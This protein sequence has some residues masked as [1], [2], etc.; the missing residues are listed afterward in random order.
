MIIFRREPLR[1]AIHR[2]RSAAVGMAHFVLR[3]AA[4]LY[5]HALKR[6]SSAG[7]SIIGA[8]HGF[9]PRA[10]SSGGAFQLVVLLWAATFFA[11][12]PAEAALSMPDNSLRNQVQLQGYVTSIVNTTDFVLD[13]SQLIRT[14]ERTTFYGITTVEELGIGDHVSVEGLFEG[15]TAVRATLVAVFNGDPQWVTIEDVVSEIVDSTTFILDDTTTV[16]IYAGTELDG[17]STVWDLNAEDLV[18][19]EGWLYD[20]VLL[21]EYVL[22][23]DEPGDPISVE[24][25]VTAVVSSTEFMLDNSVLVLTNPSTQ[26]IGFQSIPDLAPG[27]LVTVEGTTSLNGVIAESVELLSSPGDPVQMTGIVDE[28]L[29]QMRFRLIDGSIVVTDTRTDF[30]GIG[31]VLDLRPGDLVRTWGWWSENEFL[32]SWVEFIESMPELQEVTG[33]LAYLDPPNAFVLDDQT[34]VEVTDE[35]EWIALDGYDQLV[36][37]DELR[38]LGYSD[39][40]EW[41]WTIAAVEVER[42][43][44][45]GPTW[46]TREGWVEEVTG[47]L[48]VRLTDGVV[49]EVRPDAVLSELDSVE[50]LGP[51]DQLWIAAFTTANPQVLDVVRLEL[52]ER[53]GN[54]IIFVSVVESVNLSFDRFSTAN[55]YE[56]VIDDNT[57]FVNVNGLTEIVVGD[58][59]AVDG[60][61]GTDPLHPEQVDAIVVERRE[62]EDNGGDDGGSGGGLRTTVE[63]IVTELR[64]DGVFEID[65]ERLVETTEETEWRN[66]LDALEDLVVGMPVRTEIILE[67]DDPMEAVWVEGFAWV[68]PGIVDIEGFVLEIDLETSRF[69]LE[70]GEWL[71]WDDLTQID[72][73][74]DTFAEIEPGMHVIVVAVD[75][76]DNVFFALEI[77]VELEV[78]DVGA[79]GFPDEPIR[80]TLVVLKDGVAASEVATRYG[81]VVTG[82]LPG[83]MVHLF[84]WEETVN[85]T[86]LQTVLDDEDVVVLEPNRLFSDPESDPESIRRRA[87]AIDRA[88]TSDTFN[89]QDALFKAALDTAHTRSL[90]QGTLVAVIDTGVD[91]FHPLLRHRIAPGGYDFVDEDSLPWETADGIDQDGDEEIDEG[92]GHGTFVAGLVLLAAPATSILP[93]RVLD[94]DGRGSTFDISRA[95]LLAIDLGA[96]VINMSFAYPDRSRVLDRILMEASSRGVVLV[97]GAGNTGLATLPFPAADNRVLAVAAIDGDGRLTDFSNRGFEIALG[98]PGVDLYSASPGTLF[99]T[100]SGTSMAAPLV[101]GT[102]ALLRSVNPYLTPDQIS[103]ALLQGA[104]AAHPDDGLQLVLQAGAAI[105][106]VPNGP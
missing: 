6:G 98:A 16:T 26:L 13:D 104:A 32:A 103:A 89:N 76:G 101:S 25:Y 36:A 40:N 53:P 64:A 87:I 105:D 41:T 8:T 92:A 17:F 23:V 50:D 24:G 15:D 43:G 84:R 93:F 97:S 86:I 60:I 88:A 39:G 48:T 85:E 54:H 34:R 66:A 20:E 63:G 57:V 37:G 4:R 71:E 68:E 106:L 52:T 51:G 1:P 28:V 91:P 27:D 56:V 30:F 99:G 3:F 79:L 65:F 102:A 42:L 33:L 81:A 22:R 73:D 14:D 9:Y 2:R 58:W 19:V 67:D 44:Q 46:I 7:S 82:T 75:L 95:V 90:G 70:T 11:W 78:G 94:D 61:A 38:V 12:T 83:L 5:C 45:P 10:K 100:W 21:A 49:L 80:E 35:T 47:P 31:S 72:G 96:D 77:F 18:Y 59:V 62:G 29:D 55:G 74:I 69:R